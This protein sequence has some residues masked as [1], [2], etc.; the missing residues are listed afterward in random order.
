MNV[1]KDRDEMVMKILALEDDKYYCEADIADALGSRTYLCRKLFK[2]TKGST[3]K[4]FLDCPF[5]MTRNRK[6]V[7]GA[8]F[9]FA[10]RKYL[11]KYSHIEAKSD[12]L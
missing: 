10:L 4:Y 12:G 9:M 11:R 2:E 5:P 6:V 3:E 8:A 7:T 1:N